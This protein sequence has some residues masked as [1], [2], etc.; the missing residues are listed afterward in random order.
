MVPHYIAP[1]QVVWFLFKGGI[2]QVI[3]IAGKSGSGKDEVAKIIKSYY[4]KRN[5]K[6]V[7][8]RFSKYIKLFAMEMLDW[9]GSENTKP[10]KFLQD[11]G[12]EARKYNKNIFIERM[13]EDIALYEKYYSIVII[14]DV[15]LIKEIEAF[16]SSLNGVTTFH[17][18]SDKSKNKLTED[19]KNHITEVELDNYENFDYTIKN[20]FDGTLK[21]EV[22]KILEGMI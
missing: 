18:L 19:E 1:W 14:S 22:I 11:F 9:D 15:R 21:E 8:T 4:E 16:K 3:L 13:L 17:I 12:Q 7:I 2:M 5:K 10:R 20:N 6:V